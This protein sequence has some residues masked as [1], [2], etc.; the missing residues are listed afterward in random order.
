MAGSLFRGGRLGRRLLTRLVVPLV[1]VTTAVVIVPGSLR[2]LS[3]STAGAAGCPTSPAT[4]FG[5]PV[6][7]LGCKIGG[8]GFTSPTVGTINGKPV[9]VD[10]SLSGYVYVVNALTGKEM[11]GWPQRA[12]LVG[13]TAT[14]IDSSPAIAYLDGPT[15][16]PSI[17]VGLGSLYVGHQ[18]GGVMAWNWNGKV[19]FR[20]HT[21][22][23][24]SQSKGD[25]KLYSNSVFATPAIGSLS[26]SGKPDIVFGSYDHYLYA[27][28]GSGHVL[29]GFPVNRADTIW[30]SPALVDT[31]GTGKL[32]IIE[33]GDASG[34]RGPKGGPRCFSGWISDYRYVNSKPHLEWEHCL[35]EAVWSSPAIT[36]FGTT[37]VVVVGTGWQTGAGRTVLPAEDE[38]FAYNAKT[39]AP[40]KGW[41][42][43]ANGPTFGSPAVGPLVAGGP[44]E[45]VDSSCASC[46]HGPG[47]V[48]AWNEAGH[49]IWT[50]HVSARSQILASPALAEVNG[51]SRDNDVLI[52]DAAGLYVLNAATGA[53]IDGTG[54]VAMNR[55]CNVGGTPVVAPVLGSSTGYMLFTNCGFN[56]PNRTA[57]EYLRAYNIP[58]PTNVSPW[59]M[60]RDNAQRTGVP[61]PIFV[62]KARCAASTKGL[63]VVDL[64]GGVSALGGASSCGGLTGQVLPT[65]VAGMASTAD[66]GGYWVA[67]RD[68][69]VYAFGDAKSY[70][71]LRLARLHAGRPDGATGAPIIA[72]AASR[73]A[74]GY[75][76]LAGDGSVY[77]FGDAHFKGA[78]GSYRPAGKPAAIATDLATGGYWVVTSTGHVYSYGAPS[79]GS[80][81]TGR[82]S[83]VVGIAV[84]PSGTG[85]WLVTSAGAVK[86][87]GSLRSLGSPSGVTVAG[88]AAGGANGY[89]IVSRQGGIYA[90]GTAKIAGL[91][92]HVI[93][94]S[95][96]AAVAAG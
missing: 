39:G 66:G 38:I 17:V 89:Y 88:I 48:S 82:H 87:F 93:S 23:T 10:A 13:S 74:K 73:D 9:V 20:F 55:S 59:P 69:A 79:L 70:G 91:K 6:W 43:K 25:G 21:K 8:Q 35:A 96:L 86:G 12:T 40:I 11:P 36:T 31:S 95:A 3:G 28:N 63:R 5:Q 60:F 61:D 45:V 57:N 62:S 81:T 65:E 7:V 78:P 77:G 29:P 94:R 27:L 51:A 42:V 83:P 46:V 71:D 2:G 49:R 47:T 80:W 24:F 32:D 52:G 41:P 26:G 50:N 85:Y 4:G 34:W 84:A 44:N 15:A 72:M 68:G 58:A 67:L 19:R 76:L 92:V 30:S 18:N 54:T 37:P 56:G 22:H 14:A 53:K 90:F 1:L 75:L 64:T 33:G 16:E